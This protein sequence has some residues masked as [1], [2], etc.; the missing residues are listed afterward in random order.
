M[1]DNFF[2]S[3]KEIHV[4]LD[5]TLHSGDIVKETAVFMLLRMPH[6]LFACFFKS[7]F[8]GLPLKQCLAAD[9]GRS[10]V[11]LRLNDSLVSWLNSIRQ[12]YN[13]NIR[14]LIN[15]GSPYSLIDR[16]IIDRL[17]SPDGY[18]T[19]EDNRRNIGIQKISNININ[20]ICYIGNSREDFP[21]FEKVKY[22]G[23]VGPINKITKTKAF[24]SKVVF[25]DHSSDIGNFLSVLKLM[26]I[27]HW[28][29]NTLVF[30]AL[31]FEPNITV[32]SIIQLSGAFLAFC[33]LS[34]I[35]YIIN[36]LYDINADRLHQ[37][38]W[39][40]PIASG[41]I[42][43]LHVVPLLLLLTS[44]VIILITAV[45]ELNLETLS[46][47][48]IYLVLNLFYSLYLKHIRFLNIFIMPLFYILRVIF[49]L[50]CIGIIASP[51]LLTF[52][53]FGLLP[54]AVLKRTREIQLSKGVLHGELVRGY[55]LSD[56]SQLNQLASA[57]IAAATSIT[58]LFWM[59]TFPQPS[60]IQVFFIVL[61]TILVFVALWALVFGNGGDEDDTFGMVTSNKAFLV[62]GFFFI[63]IYII[64]VR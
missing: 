17:I 19:S 33:F 49:G 48:V 38:K 28:L 16:E 58:A 5:G 2:N 29:K 26:R 53:F 10:V 21:I 13:H 4:D 41:Q 57:A 46:I 24:S 42:S 6:R 39:R 22:V 15:T 25:S 61:S 1:H 64:L 55:T 7:F 36:D 3:V 35:V 60:M 45:L 52:F 27:K 23:L 34:S 31:L 54:M 32:T 56:V 8:Q 44:L 50:A 14:V 9:L 43:I 12:N 30:T 51:V 18:I 37:T 40:R 11:V 59:K 47:L 62:C 20:D 63:L